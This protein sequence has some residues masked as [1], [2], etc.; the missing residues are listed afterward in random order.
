[1]SKTL[2]A[3]RCKLCNARSVVYG[4]WCPMCLVRGVK[5]MQAMSAPL[6]TFLMENHAVKPGDKMPYGDELL[7]KLRGILDGKANRVAAPEV[8]N[9][10]ELDRPQ[11]AP[12]AVPEPAGTGDGANQADRAPA[13]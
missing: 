3:V 7:A 12:Q 2:H 6:M 10:P 8:R 11:G 4:G 9:G 13:Q 5:S 1:M